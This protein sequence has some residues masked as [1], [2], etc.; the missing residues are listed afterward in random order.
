ME[1]LQVC[2]GASTKTLLELFA[3]RARLQVLMNDWDSFIP[4]LIYK[5]ND[6]IAVPAKHRPL[7]LTSILSKIFEMG[8]A[9]RLVRDTLY[10]QQ[11][12]G[13]TEKSM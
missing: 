9:V 5:K 4:I 10:E 11:Q 13:F 3:A 2:L 7:R 8:T 1:I 12:Y 6:S